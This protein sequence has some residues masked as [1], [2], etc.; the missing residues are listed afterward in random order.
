MAAAAAATFK[1][2]N[3]HE[4]VDSL[5][6]SLFASCIQKLFTASSTATE[7]KVVGGTPVSLNVN[8]PAFARLCSMQLYSQVLTL[9]SFAART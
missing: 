2:K 8:A 1:L 7:H 5:L 4:G 9:S 6:Q 3:R